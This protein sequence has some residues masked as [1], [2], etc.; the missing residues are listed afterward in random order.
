MTAPTPR[1]RARGR[2]RCGSRTSPASLAASHQPPNEKNARTIAPASAGTR[3]EAAGAAREEGDEVRRVARARGEAPRDEAQREGR[4]WRRPGAWPMAPARRTPRRLA[5][6]IAPIAARATPFARQAGEGRLR[7]RRRG[8]WRARP[9]ARGPSR[10]GTS[11]RTGRPRPAR[12]PRAGRRRS[13]PP[14]GSGPPARRGS[15]AP[16][17]A[18]VPMN[19]HTRKTRAGEASE[20]A[21][22]AGVRKIPTPTVP[23]TT[24]AAA[25]PGPMRRC[26]PGPASPALR[27][28]PSG[29]AGRPA[30]RPSRRRRRRS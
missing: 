2:E 30:A 17:R 14:P 29:R 1:N 10:A 4:S 11:S 18:A 21:I 16:Q 15:S 13:R 27:T 26:S 19:A 20:R 8:P 7:R 22:P 5:A 9:S 28:A 25:A 12:G 23:P 6:A 24:R 3:G